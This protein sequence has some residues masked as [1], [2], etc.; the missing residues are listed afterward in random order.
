MDTYRIPFNRTSCEGNELKYLAQSIANGHISGDGYFT[1]E[2]HALLERQLGVAKALLTTSYMHAL[3]LAALLLDIKPGDEV[4]C[5][6]FNFASTIHAFVLRGAKPIFVDVRPDTF[7]LDERLLEEAITHRT[8]AITPVHYGGVACEMD[9]I[10]EIARR[11]GIAVVED[12]AHGLFAK[13]RGKH[14]GTMGSMATQSFHETKN[15]S[16]GKGGALLIN[17][18]QYVAR[19]QM[20]REQRNDRSLFSASQ[21]DRYS[22]GDIGSS[23]LPS[24]M[25]AAFL[26]GQLEAAGRIQMK[27][28]RIWDYYA[29]YLADWAAANGV[30]LPIVPPHCEHPAH[31]F[32]LLFPTGDAR[33]AMSRHLAEHGIESVLPVP[34]SDGGSQ[35]GPGA[36][37]CAVAD[38]VSDR[39]LL[40]P[41]FSGLQN[42]ELEFVVD[43]VTAYRPD[44]TPR[45]LSSLVAI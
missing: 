44:E 19:A 42:E 39:L 16:C 28:Q 24:E 34:V 45:R 13:Y 40:L 6:S 36:L 17:D 2:C 4:I 9:V 32:H 43:T 37:D 25:L 1:R 14:L 18:A 35:Y 30:G 33:K 5:P 15:F 27:R 12:N 3:E 10:G 21:R 31:L 7:N 29:E 26:Y 11:H 20:T 22:W 41:I 8:R 23:Y 38:S